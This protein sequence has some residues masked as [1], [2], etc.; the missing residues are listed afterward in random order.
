MLPFLNA[1]AHDDLALLECV[2]GGFHDFRRWMRKLFPGIDSNECEEAFAI[3][4]R[5]VQ[6][7][8]TL[9][10]G[11]VLDALEVVSPPTQAEID[12]AWTV[13]SASTEAGRRA[14]YGD[15]HPLEILARGE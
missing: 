5:A 12:A 2:A 8:Y 3:L 13:E 7:R 9:P 6:R 10:A 1:T 11:K 4:C 15:R 14:L